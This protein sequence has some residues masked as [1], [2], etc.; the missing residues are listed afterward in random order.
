MMNKLIMAALLLAGTGTAHSAPSGELTDAEAD[1]IAG[2]V[3]A[4]AAKPKPKPGDKPTDECYKLADGK[5]APLSGGR[6][7]VSRAVAQNLRLAFLLGSATLTEASKRSLDKI[8][9]RFTAGG[10][11]AQFFIDGHT[12]RSGSCTLNL[13]LSQDR[14]KS[15]VDYLA[16]AGVARDRMTPRG[17][18]FTQPVDGA[19]ARDSINRRVE[20]VAK[21][22]NG[23]AARPASC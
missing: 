6:Q 12:D 8:A 16:G 5:C 21:G 23:S 9:K 7:V 4:Q 14:A 19:D 13:A 3:S 22:G 2:A 18:G 1:A 11:S 15:A 17:F 10:N 20:I